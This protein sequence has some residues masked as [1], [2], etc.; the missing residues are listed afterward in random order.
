MSTDAAAV[1]SIFRRDH[2]AF[3][4][5]DLGAVI[6][7]TSASK[8]TKRIY[9]PP[10]TTVGRRRKKKKKMEMMRMVLKMVMKMVKMKKKKD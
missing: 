4:E 10:R 2:R 6:P 9:A 8:P 3:G 5:K 1:E 7:A